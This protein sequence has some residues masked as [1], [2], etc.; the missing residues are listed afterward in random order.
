MGVRG[1]NLLDGDEV[2]AMQ[3][4]TQGYYLLVVSENGMGKRTSISEFTCQN[5]GGKG[6]KCYKIMEKTGN[7]VGVKILNKENEILLINTEGIVIRIACEDISILGR[8]TSGVKLM[9]VGEDIKVA[10]IA[11]VKEESNK[12]D[13]DMLKTMETELEEESK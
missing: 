2:V 6:V 3:L 11:R 8:V 5:R 13:E 12:S 9:D 4:N 7:V 10:S 1:I